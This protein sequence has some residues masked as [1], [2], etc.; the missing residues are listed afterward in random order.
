MQATVRRQ[1]EFVLA[2]CEISEPWTATVS[3]PRVWKKTTPP[4]CKEWRIFYIALHHICYKSWLPNPP[5]PPPVVLLLCRSTVKR[6]QLFSALYQVQVKFPRRSSISLYTVNTEIDRTTR[7]PPRQPHWH[8]PLWNKGGCSLVSKMTHSLGN[9]EKTAQ[10][11]L[12][13]I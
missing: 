10:I 7:Q 1:V 13:F 6:L 11:Y 8:N 12:S 2:S 3:S 5:P 4:N 9:E